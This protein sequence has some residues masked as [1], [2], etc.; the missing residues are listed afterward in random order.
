METLAQHENFLG[1]KECMGNARIQGYTRQGITCW[2]GNDD[3]AHAARHECGAAGVISVTSNVIPGVFAQLMR[4]RDD[5]KGEQ[6]TYPYH[7][8]TLSLVDVHA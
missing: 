5:Q 8:I 7:A 6:R 4:E 3:E 1:M 2:S